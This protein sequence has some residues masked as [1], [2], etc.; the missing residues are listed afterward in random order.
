MRLD[1]NDAGYLMDMLL[2]GRSVRRFVQ[3][4]PAEGFA[5]DEL[6]RMAVEGAFEVIGEAPVA[7]RGLPRRTHTNAA[8]P[9]DRFAQ[10]DS[11]RLRR[12]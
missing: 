5:G 4:L 10:C 11:P 8:Q 3:G 7:V 12:N 9:D 6:R 1:E 2:A